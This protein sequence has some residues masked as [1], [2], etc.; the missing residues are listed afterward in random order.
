MMNKIKKMK[1]SKIFGTLLLLISFSLIFNKQV[2]AADETTSAGFTYNVT[3]PENQRMKKG[4]WDLLMTPGQKQKVSLTL[5]NPSDEVVN[6]D[7]TILGAKTNKNGV[8]DYVAP[9][10]VNDDSLKYPFETIVTGPEAVQLK[11]NES[12]DVEF[13]I[14]MPESDI[15]GQI[16]GG[17]SMIRSSKD[18]KEEEMDGT[19]IKNRYRYVVPLVLQTNEKP[20]VPKVEFKEIYPEQLNFK[21]TIFVDFSNTQGA[22]LN[23]MSVN[24]TITEKGK[25]T[26]LYQTKKVGMRMAPNSMIDFPVSM[27]GERMVSGNYTAVIEVNGE[28]GVAETWT[29]DFEITKE[30]SDK[31]NERDI[32]LYEEKTMDWKVIAMVVG[33][34]LALIVVIYFV[35]SRIRKKQDKSSSKRKK[36]K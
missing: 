29:E 15:E 30:Q 17:I 34:V 11:A 10:I 5:N 13:E 19:Q 27:E 28:D 33:V 26:V 31:Y 24:V 14:A 20:V 32:G 25:E 2:L 16:V 4:F 23:E 1:M 22:F 35:I 3:F 36:K 18:D 12:K 9:E 21:N 6:V 7:F 8:I